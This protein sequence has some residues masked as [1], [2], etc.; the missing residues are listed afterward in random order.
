[1]TTYMSWWVAGGIVGLAAASRL[2]RHRGIGTWGQGTI[3]V[4]ATAGFLFG[5]KI[6]YRLHVLPLWQAL[7]VH[8]AEWLSPGYYLPLGIVF[9]VGAAMLVARVQRMPVLDVADALAL[10]GPVMT[11]IGRI[12]CMIAGCCTGIVC[13]SWWPFG[14]THAPDTVAYTAQLSAGLIAAGAS[15]SLPTHPLPV[16][17]AALGIAIAAVQLRVLRRGAPAGTVAAVGFLL[18]PLGQ[19]IIECL[20]DAP[21]D[22]GP[23][24]TAVLAGI[25]ICDCVTVLAVHLGRRWR[26]SD[27]RRHADGLHAETI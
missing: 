27:G 17:F 1:M 22:R 23:V 3:L 19:L 2:L 13:P 4:A 26:A 6:Q 5:A 20:R 16:Y 11:P 21:N 9:A 8:P 15:A 24:M 18:Y 12:G 7:V 10:A 14:W 25:I